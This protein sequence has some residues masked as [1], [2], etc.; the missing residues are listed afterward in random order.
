MSRRQFGNFVPQPSNT[1]RDWTPNGTTI[2]NLRADPL[3]AAVSEFGL[4]TEGGD[5]A[6]TQLLREPMRLVFTLSEGTQI[7]SS[8]VSAK[9]QLAAR[10][11]EFT[12]SPAD[13]V[14]ARW[15][16]GLDQQTLKM[17]VSLDGAARI[18]C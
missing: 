5:R 17:V 7:H 2:Y 16:V 13:G 14:N 1:G 3:T 4:D 12:F 6:K 8:N 15:L 10:Q 9:R 11:A 18:A